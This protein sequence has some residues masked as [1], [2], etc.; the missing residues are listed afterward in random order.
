[1][2][3]GARVLSA[4]GLICCCCCCSALLRLAEVGRLETPKAKGKY[5]T[6]QL[7]LHRI[8]GYRGVILFPWSAR[9]FNRDVSASK[10]DK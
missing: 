5:A 2:F 10:R 4:V 9:V 6:G 7:L 8:F 3:Q 1:M